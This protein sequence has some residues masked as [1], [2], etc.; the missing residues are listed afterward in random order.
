[1]PE[2]LVSYH[3]NAVPNFLHQSDKLPHL[4]FPDGHWFSQPDSQWESYVSESAGDQSARTR[5]RSI[6][7]Y[8]DLIL[9]ITESTR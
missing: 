4:V 8:D 6:R 1:M 5:S 7:H 3:S 2:D 9:N